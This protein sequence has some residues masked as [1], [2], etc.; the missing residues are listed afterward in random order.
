MKF[1][2]NRVQPF[3]KKCFGGIHKLQFTEDSDITGIISDYD[4]ELKFDEIV[5]TS[6]RRGHVEKWL[7]DLEIMMKKSVKE[8]PIYIASFLIDDWLQLMLVVFIKICCP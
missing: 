1:F 7:A 3:L 5:N 6:S 4:E 2:S 8:V